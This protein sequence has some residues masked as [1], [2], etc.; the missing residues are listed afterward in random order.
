VRL[1]WNGELDP[2]TRAAG[3]FVASLFTTVIV[4]VLDEAIAAAREQRSRRQISSPKEALCLS[5]PP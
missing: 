3:P 5:R 1:A 4:G 2:I